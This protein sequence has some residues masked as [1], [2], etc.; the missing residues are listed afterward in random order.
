MFFFF[1]FVIFVYVREVGKGEFFIG[2]IVVFNIIRVTLLRKKG[3]MGV[4]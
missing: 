4:S 2:Y 1:L 3:R